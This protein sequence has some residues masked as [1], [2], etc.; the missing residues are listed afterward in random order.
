V[1]EKIAAHSAPCEQVLSEEKLFC[2][3][4]QKNHPLCAQTRRGSDGE[5][6]FEGEVIQIFGPL[7]AKNNR[8][9]E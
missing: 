5:N 1:L 8:R 6:Q 9:D 7:G 2:L 3:G 4:K